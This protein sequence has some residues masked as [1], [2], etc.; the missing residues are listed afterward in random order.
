MRFGC[1]HDLL[2]AAGNLGH[3]LPARDRAAPLLP[4]QLHNVGR[5]DP[6]LSFKECQS[7]SAYF[8]RPL[9]PFMQQRDGR[10]S[11]GE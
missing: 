8:D 5:V 6:V 9:S 1:L 7:M 2:I 11:T 10:R 4:K 3:R